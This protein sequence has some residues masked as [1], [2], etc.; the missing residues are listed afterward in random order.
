MI[1]SPASAESLTAAGDS[2]S[3]FD[4]CSTVAGASMRV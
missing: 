1:G 4:F 3:S 2:F